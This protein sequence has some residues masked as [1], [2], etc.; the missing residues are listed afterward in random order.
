MVDDY[1]DTEPRMDG[2]TKSEA[3]KV[4]ADLTAKTKPAWPDDAS[5]ARIGGYEYYEKLFLG[6]HFSAFNM[7]IDDEHFNR[8]WADLRYIKVNFAGMITKIV[9][10]MLFSEPVKVRMPEGDQEFVENL[11]KTNNLDT[12]LYES[13]LSNSYKGDGIFK[14]RIGKKDF[15]QDQSTVIIEDITPNIYFPEV[16]NF[17]VRE[18]P[19]VETLAWKIKIGKD[20]YLRQEI[21]TRGQIENK[22]FLMKGEKIDKEVDLGMLG[23]DDLKNLE[24]TEVNFNLLEHVPNWKTGSLYFG[25][26]DYYDLDSLFFAINNRMSKVDNILDKHS[27]PILAVPPGILDE[28]GRV[29]KKSLGVIEIEEG[30]SG[31]PTYIT[32]DASLENAF[33]EIEKLVEFIYMIGEVSPDVLGMGEGQS[34]SGRA[35][36]FKLMRTIAKVARKKLYY[37]TAIKRVLYKAQVLAKQYNIKID[38]KSLQGDPMMPE[39]EWSDGLPI[40]GTEMITD[41]VMQVDA[42]L[43]SKKA[44]IMTINQVDEESAKEMLKEA[45]DESKKAFEGMKL[46]PNFQPAGQND[47]QDQGNE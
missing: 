20:Y 42:G 33:S 38:G 5:K 45:D 15:E 27:D 41:E 19:A 14:L 12:Q 16:S 35:L 18:R 11:W 23:I 36:K 1:S 25:I 2:P 39:L 44:A 17:N 30:E 3:E 9:A 7:A 4:D 43:K 13:A 37:D 47:D 26:S 21:H 31:Q 10:D 46:T 22:L 28:K 40:D 8:R 29:K 6:Q 24:K 34:D 32:W